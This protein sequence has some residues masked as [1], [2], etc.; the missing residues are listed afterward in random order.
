MVLAY[1][2]FDDGPVPRPPSYIPS[3]NQKV[4]DFTKDN[5]ECNYLI[6]FFIAGVFLLGFTDA[7]K[8]N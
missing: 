5:T 6:I 4:P 8:K 1:A 2:P 7:I 3:I